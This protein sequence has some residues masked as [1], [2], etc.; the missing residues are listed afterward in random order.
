MA[1]ARG[2]GNVAWQRR[3]KRDH[4]N[5]RSPGRKEEGSQGAREEETNSFTDSLFHSGLHSL[6]PSF[7]H[8]LSH[9]FTHAVN[10]TMILKVKQGAIYS[11]AAGEMP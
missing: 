3:W 8:S 1:M 11:L 5:D 2:S 10:V 6:M 7:T 9:S 4:S